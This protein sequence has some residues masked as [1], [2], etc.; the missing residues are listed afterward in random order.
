MRIAKSVSDD[1][2]PW[3]WALNGILGVLCSALAVFVSI[4]SGIS[5]SFYF[6]AVCYAAVLPCL[7]RMY[8]KLKTADSG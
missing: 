7:G 3:Y 6:A 2:T 1:D 5:T 4:Y 8:K